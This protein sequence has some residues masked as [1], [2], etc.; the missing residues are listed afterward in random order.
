MDKAI[1]FDWGRTLY[2]SETKREF[3]DAEKVLAHCIERGYR[4]AVVSLVSA[5][6]NSTLDERVAVIE[7]SSLRKYFEIALVTDKNKDEILDSVVAHFGLPLD[8]VYIVD[9]RIIR[10]IKYGNAHG[11]PTI[12]FQNGK[13][14]N[15][16]PDGTT[17]HPMHTIES[18]AELLKLL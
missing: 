6:A 8:S 15:E 7:K 16:L 1:I 14:A 18:L 11:H 10:G 12:W 2:D 3:P 17:G 13:F 4:L 9:D 5:Q